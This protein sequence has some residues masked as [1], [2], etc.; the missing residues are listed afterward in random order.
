MSGTTIRTGTP[1]RKRRSRLPWLMWLLAIVG[2]ITWWALYQSRWFLIEEVKVEGIKRLNQQTVMQVAQV[3]LG[4]PVIS[5]QPAKISKRLA[6][7]PQIKSV[8]VE[9]GWPHSVLIKVTERSPVA[10]SIGRTGFNLIDDE[11]MLAGRSKIKPKKFR[12]ITAKPNTPAMKSAVK[13]AL[14]MPAK[15]KVAKITAE[16]SNSVIV[17]LIHGQT[18]AFGS[19]EQAKLKVKV[20]GSLIINNY[21]HINVS[22]PLSPSVRR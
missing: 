13:I 9:R 14:A 16:N 3:K 21:R 12:L 18:I 19:G 1:V 20:V 17:E 7:I 5:A 11:G 22:T 10:A 2:I 6:A 15:W 4:E 8:Q